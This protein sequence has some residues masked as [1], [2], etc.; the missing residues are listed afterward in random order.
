MVEE[1]S[2]ELAVSSFFSFIFKVFVKNILNI[3]IGGDETFKASL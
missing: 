1:T 2:Y 3:L